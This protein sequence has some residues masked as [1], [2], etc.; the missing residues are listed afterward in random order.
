MLSLTPY[1]ITIDLSFSL[2]N[3]RFN[4]S[5]ISSRVFKFTSSRR[6]HKI[7]QTIAK[8]KE[9]WGFKSMILAK[10]FI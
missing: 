7:F 5:K 2:E 3:N 10:S 6:R 8:I 9:V 1:I 4:E